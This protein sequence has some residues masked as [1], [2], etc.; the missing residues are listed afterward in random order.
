M[1]FANKIYGSIYKRMAVKNNEKYFNTASVSLQQIARSSPKKP[2]DDINGLQS[3]VLEFRS[4]HSILELLR[5]IFVLQL[6]SVKY[7][8]NNSEKLME[9][10]RKVFGR[11]LFEKFM[12][13]TIYGHFVAGDN[14]QAIEDTFKLANARGIKL[15]VFM[16]TEECSDEE[17]KIKWFKDNEV[18][19]YKALH[20][21]IKQHKHSDAPEIFETK[22]TPY[23]DFALCVKLSDVI[24]SSNR[25]DVM[26]SLE[27]ILENKKAKND[28]LSE[29][30]CK[31]ELDSL[32]KSL[33]VI[34]GLCFF[35]A[36]NKLSIIFDA[37][38]T[39][40]NPALSA[41]NYVLMRKY[42]K[43]HPSVLYTYQ[44]N[45]KSTHVE[46]MRDIQNCNRDA[47]Y[48]GFKLV[49]GAYVVS[50]TAAALTQNRQNPILESF[51]AVNKN[52][53]NILRSVLTSTDEKLHVIIASH[54]LESIQLAC[55]ILNQRD[56]S[57]KGSKIY[58][59]QS[60][61]MCDFI[62]HTLVKHGH[63]VYKNLPYGAIDDVMPYLVRRVQ[64]NSSAFAGWPRE[65][66]VLLNDFKRRLLFK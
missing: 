18:A 38:Y 36:A 21:M 65:K 14:E 1:R 63:V 59:A 55:E 41:F 28:L 30:L 37:E 24:N 11:K 48:N 17:G 29:K 15:M 9:I 19:A 53:N 46:L 64:E 39:W 10:G 66:T 60:Y 52:Y 33:N 32:R 44:A 8:A 20:I 13:L 47:I 22:L 42:N 62:A 26:I 50:E 49:R 56:T 3:N 2:A 16:P 27:N 58:F 51:E 40:I 12:K 57:H 4:D 6:C 54:N 43:D 31:K 61:G 34:S 25:D 7:V 45:L 23:V 35:A 5:A